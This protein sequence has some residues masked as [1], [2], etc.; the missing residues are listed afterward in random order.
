MTS[1]SIRAISEHMIGIPAGTSSCGRGHAD[2]LDG[3]GGG[4]P[5]GPVPR[6]RGLLDRGRAVLQPAL[7]G[8]GARACYSIGDYPDAHDVIRHR[9]ADGSRVI[10]PFR[11]DAIGFR[12]GR[13][14]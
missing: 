7:G 14:L 9:E 12:L 13:S 3:R 8:D 10:Q 6:D 1:E 5:T 2:D 4:L 11:I